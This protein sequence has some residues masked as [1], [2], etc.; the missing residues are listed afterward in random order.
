MKLELL[1]I[2]LARHDWDAMAC[3]CGRSAAHLPHELRRLAAAATD[4][5][6][7]YE[8]IVGHVSV[9]E[10]LYEPAFPA[11]AVTLAALAGELSVPARRACVELLSMLT[12]GED[13]ASE[14]D[15]GRDLSAECL[16][17]AR[18]A[19]WLLY[20]DVFASHDPGTVS[21]AFELLL[22][23]DEDEDRVERV[24]EALGERLSWDLRH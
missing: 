8:G 21:T 18:G 9:N 13:Q 6:A 23:L 14:V 16:E 11:T 24:R 4:E 2:E 22:D 5:Q 1:E 3:G 17:L 12:A 19:I 10:V 15:K 20:A 7:T